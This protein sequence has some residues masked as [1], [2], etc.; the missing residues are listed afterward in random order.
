MIK[1]CGI[2]EI[3]Q[4]LAAAGEGADFIGLVFAPSRR[5][6]KVTRAAE[7]IQAVRRRQNPPAV[8]G[9][10]V[11]SS[12]MEVNVTADYCELDYIQLSGEET[13]DYCRHL[14]RPV[15]KTLHVAAA[16]T[17]QSII[18]EIQTGYQVLP[19]E[20]LIFHLDTRVEG[21]YGGT[22]R[23]FDLQ[24]AQEV[25]ARYPVIIAGGLTC[26]NASQIVKQVRPWGVDVSSGVETGGKKDIRK[27]KEFIRAVRECDKEI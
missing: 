10:F 13:W 15:I 6:I 2:T 9:V 12:A 27:I 19:A 4:A 16:S 20:R 11:N 8:A 5:M 3:E 7:I 18:D 21:L 1:I 25:A 23:T 17:P 24:L 26:G 22:G 14:K